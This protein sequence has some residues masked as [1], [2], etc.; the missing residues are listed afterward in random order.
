[1]KN[2]KI[3]IVFS[4]IL[5]AFAGCNSCNQ[6]KRNE[7]IKIGAI[8]PLTGNSAVWGIPT[9]EGIELAVEQY[10]S[11]IGINGKKIE[12]IFEDTKGEPKTGVTAA[13]KLITT[14]KV[15]ALLDNSNSSI[16]LAVA[17]T[18]EKNKI[19]LMV[20]GAS[21]PKITQAG[22]YVYRIWNSDALEGELM[23]NFAYDSLKV[24]K[25]C[26]LYV[27]NNYGEGLKGVF[28][29]FFSKRGGNIISEESFQEDGSDFR[30][31]VSNVI[32][33]KPDA[34]YLVC[35]PK[36]GAILLKQLK[37]LNYNKILL[38]AVAFEDPD[39]IKLSGNAAEGLIY[40]L[41]APVDTTNSIYE[42]FSAAYKAK[43]NKQLPFLADVGYDGF[44]ILIKAIE[45]AKSL[46]GDKIKLEL[47]KIQ[48]FEGV[49]GNISFDKN[50]DV[51]KHFGMRIVKNNS[52]IWLYK[53]L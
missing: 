31:Q 11:K 50:G 10:N 43:F 20:T 41:P 14:D 52:P 48:N 6:Q 45:N 26:I 22:E 21:S 16:T 1:M 30:T 17:P 9:K 35:Y 51:H 29:E 25:C 24:K 27:N 23:G 4:G 2:L 44:N 47:D 37:E 3:I 46:D 49:S 28:T 39:L 18:I 34:V 19:P 12:I 40:P 8:L 32:N 7:T 33:S 15:V 42:S 36:Q 53:Q 38:G 5:I 13:E